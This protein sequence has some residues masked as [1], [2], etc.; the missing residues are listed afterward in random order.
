[1]G[2]SGSTRWRGHAR[3]PTIEEAIRLSV[4]DLRE[5]LRNPEPQTMGWRWA[6]DGKTTAEVGLSMSASV[7]PLR[8]PLRTVASRTVEFSFGITRKDSIEPV[9][10]VVS[11]NAVG[12]R[13]GGVRWRFACPSCGSARQTLYLPFRFGGRAWRCRGCH[14]LR[15]KTQRAAPR[16]RAEIRMQRLSQRVLR[17][18]WDNWDASL[19]PKPKGMHRSTY[20]KHH[21][22]WERS[23]DVVESEYCLKVYRLM[24]AMHRIGLLYLPGM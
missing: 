3:R 13:F 24:N 6:R 21:A 2:G 16:Y 12:M 1:M 20:A 10:Q 7:K 4:Q 15:Y 19:P 22:R 18:P 14:D 11:L 8:R 9:H 5:F 23:A 17:G